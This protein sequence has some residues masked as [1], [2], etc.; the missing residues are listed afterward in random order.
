MPSQGEMKI[1][2]WN[3]RGLN[4]PNMERLIKSNLTTL[5]SDIVMIQET[6]LREEDWSNYNMKL[7]IWKVEYIPVE[8]TIRG[9]AILWDPRRVY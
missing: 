1:I 5:N 8:G 4:T 3:V 9:L 2:T 6:K 7:G